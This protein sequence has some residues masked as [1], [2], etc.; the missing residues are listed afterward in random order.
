MRASIIVK[1]VSKQFRRPSGDR[2]TSFKES[3]LTGFRSGEMHTF[4]ALRDV[5]FTVPAGRMVGVV[6]KNGAGKSTLLR[7]IGGVGQPTEGLID[8]HG[9]VGALLDL[10]AGLTDDLTGR[11]NIF[12][13]GVIAGMTRAEVRGCY[14]SIV[15]FAELESFIEMPIRTYSSGMRMRLAF[16][17][18]AHMSPDVLLIDEVLAVGDLHFQRKCLERIAAIKA[19]GATIFLVSHDS[20]QV[21]ALCDEVLLLKQGKVVAYGP[22]QAV[23]DLYESDALPELV[24]RPETSVEVERLP[25]GKLLQHGVNRSGSQEVQIRAVRLLHPNGAFARSIV[26]G[27]G[28]AVEFDL[29]AHNPVQ[30]ALA[31]V[32]IHTDDESPC[33]DTNTEVGGVDL[34]V[35]TGLTTLRLAFDRLDLAGGNYSI[36]VGVYQQGWQGIYDHHYHCYDFS[37][38]GPHSGKGFMNP[39][40][41]WSRIFAADVAHDDVL[42]IGCLPFSKGGEP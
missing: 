38:V 2:L 21:R 35:L 22:T 3:V 9:R 37:V 13:A 16:S 39:P 40:S 18:A 5:S 36:S 15:A 34:S 4:W 32:T 17:V 25:G 1:G 7:L 6:G 23:M 20:S 24:D 30:A 19:S 33:L 10:N 27:A 14:D 11:E 12:I 28:L 41:A 29:L 31:S 8:V 26:S 42:G